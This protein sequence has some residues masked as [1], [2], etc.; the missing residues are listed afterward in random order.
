LTPVREPPHNGR[1][2]KALVHTKALTFEMQERE[3][4]KH[5]PSD[6]LVRVVA[7]GICGS[8][9]HGMTGQTGRR[10]PPIVMG[11]EAAGVVEAVGAAVTTFK[12]GDRITFDSTIYCNRCRYCLSGKPNLCSNR[13]VLGVSC[14]EYRQDGAMADF[15]VVPEHIVV[16]L[17]QGLDFEKA[18]MVEPVSI[19]VHAVERAGIH[20]GDN[21]VVVGCGII[22]LLTIQAARLAGAGRVIAV[23]VVDYK[24]EEARRLGADH[25]INS[26]SGDPVQAIQAL[27]AGEGAD[28]AL[29]AV[30]FPPTVDLAVR[31]VRKGGRCVLIG[32][33]T[34]RMDFPAQIVVQRELDVRGTVASAGEYPACLTLIASGRLDVASLISRTV[35][36]EEA[37][38]WFH[39]LHEGKERLFK[40]MLKP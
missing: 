13:K 25:V 18:A 8:D 32:N 11:H 29:E 30:G 12:K 17:P 2:M 7:V 6:V 38:H 37:P 20:L 39:L 26:R 19:A 3:V 5:G 27:T 1:D 33:L 10:I 23:D 22:G 31:C 28:V 34:P 15:V 4:P 14:D 16:P 24:L 36:L 21:V 40:V 35:P 9:V